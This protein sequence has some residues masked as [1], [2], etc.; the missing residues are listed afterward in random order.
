MDT[1]PAQVC[2][3][4]KIRHDVQSCTSKSVLRELSCTLT[5]LSKFSAVHVSCHRDNTEYLK[6][7]RNLLNVLANMYGIIHCYSFLTVL[8]AL[9]CNTDRE[10]NHIPGAEQ[11]LLLVY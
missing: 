2:G 7:L 8:A 9:H 10:S 4:C 3:P 5:D 11:I 6:T 1:R